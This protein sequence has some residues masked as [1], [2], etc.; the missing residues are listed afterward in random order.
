MLPPPSK[1]ISQELFELRERIAIK[2][3]DGVQLT[4]KEATAMRDWIR[5]QEKR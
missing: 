4:A 3:A 1:L 2:V 5:E